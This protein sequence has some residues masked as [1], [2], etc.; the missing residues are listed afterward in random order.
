[1]KPEPSSDVEPPVAALD[2]KA[3]ECNEEAAP[4]YY[5]N[6]ETRRV[7]QLSRNRKKRMRKETRMRKE[8]P[9]KHHVESTGAAGF[10]GRTTAPC[11]NMCT[12]K[13]WFA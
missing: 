1:M 3:A 2:P 6:K 5:G 9:G 4:D 11:S 12:W 7:T 10:P 13:P 8:Q